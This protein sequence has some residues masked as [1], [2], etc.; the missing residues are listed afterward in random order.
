MKT[1]AHVALVM[2]REDYGRP[3]AIRAMRVVPVD[4]DAEGRMTDA[5]SPSTSTRGA[6]FRARTLREWAQAMA[7]ESGGT[8][9]LFVAEVVEPE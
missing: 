4:V 1:L 8:A 3:P 6:R 9:L 2:R 5:R 7:N